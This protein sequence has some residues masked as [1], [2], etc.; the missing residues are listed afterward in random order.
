M[1]DSGI[2]VDF[3]SVDGTLKAG[4]VVSAFHMLR[5]MALGVDTINSARAMMFTLECIQSRHCN[6]DTCPRGI[7]TQNPARCKVLDVDD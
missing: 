2:A 4:T 1:I 6:R 7:A 5:L 3:I